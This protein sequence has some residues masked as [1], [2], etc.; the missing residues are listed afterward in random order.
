MIV[1]GVPLWW[2][3]TSTYRIAFRNFAPEQHITI[4]NY[5]PH[6]LRRLL[7]NLYSIG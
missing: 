4:P 1:F 6:L 3:T 5:V 2:H 7:S